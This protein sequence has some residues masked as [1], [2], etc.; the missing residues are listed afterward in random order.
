MS[1]TVRHTKVTGGAVDA[2]YSVDLH[3]WDADHAVT[4]TVEITEGGTGSTTASDARTA[5]GL[6]IGTD[7]QAYDAELTAIA[8]LTSAADKGIQFTGAGTAATYDLTAAG[9]ALLDDANAAAQRTTLSLGNVDNTSD[10][11]KPVS[12]ATQ[13]ALDLKL[14]ISAAREV[15]SAARTYYVRTDGSDSNTGLVDS[16]GGAFLTIQ[17]AINTVGS[18]DMSIYQVTVQVGAGTYTGAISFKNYVGT[19]SPILQGDTTTP[20]NVVVNVTSS[21]AVTA[22]GSPIWIIKGFQVKTTTSGY[23]IR[24]KN[25]GKLYFDKLDFAASANSHFYVDS[26]AAVSITGTATYTIS[27][28]PSGDGIHAFATNGGFLDTASATVTLTGTPNF[29][30]G[31]ASA[32]RNGI[33]K[34]FSITFSGSATGARRNVS[35]GGVCYVAGAGDT[36]FPG[37]SIGSGTNSATSPYGDYV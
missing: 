10:A 25:G 5:L 20:S 6:A 8:G 19:L 4:G 12:T 11:N 26:A 28:A 27:G 24:A 23:V 13:T 34:A 32:S 37:D 2:R 35:R 14:N 30:G 36:Y 17:K 3:D 9:K 22:D 29:A 33:Y 7:V 15:L 21:D 1:Q 16:A 18:I 31:Y